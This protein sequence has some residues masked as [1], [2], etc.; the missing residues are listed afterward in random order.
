MMPAMNR[1][2]WDEGRLTLSLTKGTEN[3]ACF[4][5]ETCLFVQGDD[6]CI[7]QR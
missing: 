2:E 6:E 4:R 7:H 5:K 3:G 1:P